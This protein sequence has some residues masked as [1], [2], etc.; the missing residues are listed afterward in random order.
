MA[1]SIMG[2]GCGGGGARSKFTFWLVVSDATRPIGPKIGTTK[3]FD[4]KNK[5]ITAFF[6]FL[7]IDLVGR[8]QR[9][10]FAPKN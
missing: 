8:G 7:K 9:S 3:Q 1:M 4:P 10:N 5:P 2:G 6:K